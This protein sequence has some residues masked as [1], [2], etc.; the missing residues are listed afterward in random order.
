M[1]RRHFNFSSRC[2]SLFLG[3]G[4]CRQPPHLGGTRFTGCRGS[5]ASINVEPND[6]RDIH[7]P[8]VQML[9]GEK[10]PEHV[11]DEEDRDVFVVQVPDDEADD[12]ERK[13]D[14]DVVRYLVEKAK[15][16]P[17][18]STTEHKYIT[19]TAEHIGVL[20]AILQVNTKVLCKLLKNKHA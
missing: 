13:I 17:V 10:N 12:E 20:S 15:P 19:D 4:I 14:N 6:A 2:G 5:I 18:P 9:D 8:L 1:N 7:R 11:L 3:S 16:D